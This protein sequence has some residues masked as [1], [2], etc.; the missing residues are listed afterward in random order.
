MDINS[1][2]MKIVNITPLFFETKEDV[3]LKFLYR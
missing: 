3:L 2:K 1:I